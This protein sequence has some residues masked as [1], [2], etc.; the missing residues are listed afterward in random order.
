MIKKILIIGAFGYIGARMCSFFGSKKEYFVTALGRAEPS[1]ECKWL[2]EI[3]EVIIGDIRDNLIIDKLL[4]KNFDVVINLVSL[5][6]KGSETSPINLSDIN[7]MPTW[8]LLERLTKNNL[9]M[10]IY[11]STIHVYGN[12]KS[13]LIDESYNQYPMNNYGLTHQISEKVV[14]YYNSI[15]K[16]KC[17]SLRLSNGYGS[18]K[19]LNESCWSLVLNNMCKS[20][21]Q[22][23]K[24]IITSDGTPMCDFIHMDDICSAVEVLLINYK[25]FDHNVFNLC[26]M[27]SLSISDVAILVQNFYYKRYRKKIPIQY[28]MKS[29][30][31]R[32]IE[33]VTDYNI[34]NTRLKGIGFELSISI[35]DGIN[36]LFKYFEN[37]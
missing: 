17:I 29:I 21:Y 32:K 27:K 6:Q 30:R 34:D 4:L 23:K 16:T 9:K 33:K 2:N 28:S 1:S 7:I 10:F 13:G 5:N 15:S 8:N 25:S 11:F 12:L 36:E 19:I 20:A 22:Q 3:D 26:S 18:P 35:E 31:N 24:I 14:D 37:V